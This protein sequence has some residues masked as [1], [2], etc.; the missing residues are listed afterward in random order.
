MAWVLLM[1]PF[2]CEYR[3]VKKQAREGEQRGMVTKEL[4]K[5][6]PSAAMRSMLGVLRNGWPAQERQS[7]RWSSVRMKRMLGFSAAEIEDKHKAHRGH[8]EHRVK[9][10][11]DFILF[12]LRALCI[13]CALCRC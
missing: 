3:P 4:L 10:Q 5:Y 1:T 12:F 9:K 11:N 8:R 2:A 13:L 6:A 7:Q